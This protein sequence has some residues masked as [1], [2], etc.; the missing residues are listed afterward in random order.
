[1]TWCSNLTEDEEAKMS[2]LKLGAIADEKPV[3]L[4]AGAA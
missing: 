4:E 3:K 2:K 1:V